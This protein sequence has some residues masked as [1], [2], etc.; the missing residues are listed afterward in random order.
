MG[1]D[2]LAAI[3]QRAP[4]APELGSV[5]AHHSIMTQQIVAPTICWIVPLCCH[6]NSSLAPILHLFVYLDAGGLKLGSQLILGFAKAKCTVAYRSR[7]K[8]TYLVVTA[9]R[10]GRKESR[11]VN[12]I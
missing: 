12:S 1:G 6:G 2:L 10:R 7:P 4:D 5:A 8:S 9:E 11:I 3:P